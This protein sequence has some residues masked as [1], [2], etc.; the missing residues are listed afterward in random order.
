MIDSKII[1]SKT[2]LKLA[3][4]GLM[5]M[6]AIPVT[7]APM[8]KSS[9]KISSA[10]VTIGD[11][12]DG[13]GINAESALFRAPAPGTTGTV[14]LQSIR[15][16]AA[17][18]GLLD[19]GTD[20]VYSVSVS[21]TG[22]LIETKTL[23][24]LI[25]DELKS[26]GILSGGVFAN[27]KF[28]TDFTSTYSTS[29]SEPVQLK[30]LNYTPSSNRFSAIFQIAGENKT[31][32]LAGTLNLMIEVPHLKISLNTGAI[33]SAND[34]EML[35]VAMRYAQ[36]SGFAMLEQIVGKQLLRPTRAGMLIRPSD[37]IEP[38]IVKRSQM[39]T[40]YYKK[41]PLTLTASG[42]ALNSAAKGEMVSVLNTTSKQIVRGIATKSGAVEIINDAINIRNTKG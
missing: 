9:I 5:S 37:I 13:A 20:G 14:S 28:S 22:F 26:N 35:P 40:L 7:A 18:V 11:M 21:R 42:Q 17:K 8:L 29:A 16:A 27:P 25:I 31:H 30:E 24:N 38:E 15:Q 36:N 39:V 33:I 32:E 12:F 4:I 10:V 41:G 6:S 19:Y 34:V 1:K 23:N 3:L 2:I